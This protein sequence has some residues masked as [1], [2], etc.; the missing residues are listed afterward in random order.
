MKTLID[1]VVKI[2]TIVVNQVYTLRGQEFS[3]VFFSLVSKSGDGPL[4]IL[5]TIS[6][7]L[8]DSV[9]GQAFFTASL[10][11][12]CIELPVYKAIK[13]LVKRLRPFEKITTIKFLVAPPDR[14]SFPSGHT[15]SAFLVWSILSHLFPIFLIPGFLWASAIGF[16]RVYLGVHY[17]SDI[18]VGIILGLFC[19]Q[20]GLSFL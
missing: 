7:W 5:L 2:D 1:N 15:A 18:C 4:Y 6:L 9:V 13:S 8:F 20:I 17:P 11:A 3:D 14:F 16:S 10:I 19:A 12:F